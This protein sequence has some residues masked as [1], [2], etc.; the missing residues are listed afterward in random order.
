[1]TY[2]HVPQQWVRC[3]H[4]QTKAKLRLFCLPYGG[5]DASLFHA[6]PEAFSSD[7]QE[8]VE[9]C[10]IELPGRAHRL[11]ERPLFTTIESLVEALVPPE[12]ELSPLYPYLQRPF[13]IF[14]ASVGGL[15]GF[16]LARALT[17]QYGCS[18]ISLCVAA[19]RAPHLPSPFVLNE[20]EAFSQAEL[21]EQLRQ[22][23]GTPEYILADTRIMELALPKLHAD[24]LLAAT[25][26]CRP[27]TPLACPITAIG[28]TDDPLVSA[29][30][31]AGWQ[32]YTRSTFQFHLLP[33]D[34]F[35]VRDASTENRARLLEYVARTLRRSL[36]S[37]LVRNEASGQRADSS[38]GG[39]GE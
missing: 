14:G 1:M 33:G 21:M 19:T 17:E 27:D 29:A 16:E 35:F 10:P 28:G 25:Y 22:Y 39:V 37:S 3:H 15:I 34:H 30:D 9:I 5:G 8:V 26:T 32:A 18:P 2:S 36:P 20:A 23:G 4:P 24:S 38:S 11:R 7:L 13:A 6:W 31:L 12:P